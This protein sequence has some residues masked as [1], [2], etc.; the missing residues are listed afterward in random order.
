MINMEHPLQKK[1]KAKKGEKGP[2]SPRSDRR[3]DLDFI[4]DNYLICFISTLPQGLA[5][6]P[7]GSLQF[8][9]ARSQSEACG[10]GH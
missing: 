10:S 2:A 9:K 3:R 8:E 1:K 7:V 6:R 4:R 5:G